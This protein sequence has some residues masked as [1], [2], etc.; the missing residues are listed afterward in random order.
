MKKIVK[1]SLILG[2]FLLAIALFANLKAQASVE[3]ME[4]FFEFPGINVQITATNK[5]QPGQNIT[6]ILNLQLRNDTDEIYMQYFNLSIF[7]FLYGENRVLLK[8][9][10]RNGFSLNNTSRTYNCAF[11]VSMPANIWGSTYGEIVLSYWA[12][13]GIARLD[14]LDPP[15]S[16]GF[17]ATYVENV[18]LKNLEELL[19][20]LNS[21][22]RQSFQMNLTLENLAKLNETYWRLHGSVD[23]LDNTRKAVAILAI[24]TVF[25]VATTVYVVWRKP[26]EYW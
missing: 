19:D 13:Y 2:I 23:D 9:E 5:T 11:N 4:T 3:N 8:N 12:R 22:F 15:L 6:V 16:S 10:T 26:K 18:Y 21:T 14:Y 7:G 25:F 1:L 17:T 24:T 20:N